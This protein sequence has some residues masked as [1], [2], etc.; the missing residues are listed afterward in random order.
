MAAASSGAAPFPFRTGPANGHG[1][2]GWRRLGSGSARVRSMGAPGAGT[3]NITNGGQVGSAN[4]N[5][6]AFIG[7]GSG[8]M[9]AVTVDGTGSAWSGIS[10]LY[11]GTG[12]GS[13][14]LTTSNGATQARIGNIYVGSQIGSQGGNGTFDI[15]SGGTVSSLGNAKIGDGRAP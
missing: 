6:Q 8:S 10:N 2:G 5:N 11:I 15:L 3:L 13:G 14:T 7:Y 4:D 9:G 1:D 12:G